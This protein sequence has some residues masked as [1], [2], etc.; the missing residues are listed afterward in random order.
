[1]QYIGVGGQGTCPL[2]FLIDVKYILNDVNLWGRRSF[3]QKLAVSDKRWRGGVKIGQK[4]VDI[5]FNAP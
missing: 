5:I 3:I 1:M 2:I 4:L